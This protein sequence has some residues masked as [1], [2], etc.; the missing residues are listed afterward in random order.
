[1]KIT[2]KMRMILVDWLVEVHRMFKLLN[3]TLFLGIWIV[4]RYLEMKKNQKRSIAISW[5]YCY[6]NCF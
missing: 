3:E 1:M 5:Y 4:D 6:V 2:E